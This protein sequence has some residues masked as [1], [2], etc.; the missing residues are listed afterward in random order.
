MKTIEQFAIE[1]MDNEPLQFLKWA[2]EMEKE[3]VT[4]LMEIAK[5]HKRIIKND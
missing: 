2:K 5:E 4:W 1:F 3:G